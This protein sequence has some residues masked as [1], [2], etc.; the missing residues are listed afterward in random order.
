MKRTIIG[1]VLVSLAAMLPASA[2]LTTITSPPGTVVSG[3]SLIALPGIPVDPDPLVVMNGIDIDG[4]LTRWDAAT[5]SLYQYDLWTPEVFG[6][7]LLTDG[8]WVQSDS[9]G[10]ISYAG[11]DD[12]NSM[13]VWISLPKAGWS[14]IGNPFNRDFT[15]ADAKVVDGNVTVSLQDAAYTN[16]WL[17]SVGM[18]WDA[19][20]QSLYDIGLPDDWPYTETMQAWH[21]YWI[22]SNVDKIALILESS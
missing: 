17:S 13:D 12:N 11:L 22:Q 18:W 4:K 7:M 1:L 15:W 5:Q 16:N 10:T 2:A 3:W 6:N 9:P 21:G 20:T 14:L 19:G 8:Y